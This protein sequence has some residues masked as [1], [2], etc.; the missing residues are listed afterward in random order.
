MGKRVLFYLKGFSYILVE[1]GMDMRLFI[2]ILPIMMLMVI[3]AFVSFVFNDYMI[4]HGLV[5]ER[6]C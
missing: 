5:R 2:K 4:E 6:L 1:V 3:T